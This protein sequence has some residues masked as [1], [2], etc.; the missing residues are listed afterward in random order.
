MTTR[1]GRI[2]W[3]VTGAGGK[4]GRDVAAELA[5]DPTAEVTAACRA[6]LDITDAAAVREAVAGHD[7]V[8]NAAAWTDVDGAEAAEAA[9]TA[10]NGTAVRR[11][12][13]A[14]RATGVLLLHVSSDYVFP[15][16][17]GKPYAEDASPAPLSAYGRGKLAGEQAVVE[18]LPRTGCVVRTAWL[19][20]EHGRDFPAT[21]LE[22][23]ARQETLQ[24]VNDQW[25]QP[26]WSRALARQ[27][28]RLGRAALAGRAPA[29]IY[30]GTAAGCTTWYGFARTVFGLAGLDPARIR[31]VAS[32]AF[33]RPAPRPAFSA[34]THDRWTAAGMALL[35][36]WQDSLAEAFRSPAF[37]GR[38]M[39]ARRA[40]GEA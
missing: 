8:V 36:P 28:G 17:A 40:S 1:T 25:G 38:A 3:L 37:A 12:A 5:G 32:T 29:G 19:Y 30:H 31:P 20:G 27:L 4:L 24:V 2:R 35:P 21:V 26:T 6:A 14:C 10:V 23:A 18:L 9:A 15:G 34:L 16:D 7:I 22:L 39:A 33:P 13:E 11:L